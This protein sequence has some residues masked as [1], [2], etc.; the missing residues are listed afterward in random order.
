MTDETEKELIK[1]L[2]DIKSE[3]CW[4]AIII[5]INMPVIALAIMLH[6]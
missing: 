1:A 4:I 2:K 3:L 5:S 6:K